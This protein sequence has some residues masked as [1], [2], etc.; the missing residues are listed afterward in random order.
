MGTL[1]DLSGPV[2]QE[3]VLIVRFWN[4]SEGAVHSSYSLAP[5]NLGPYP[6]CSLF[7][8]CLQ[9]IA[10]GP[11]AQ[12]VLPRQEILARKNFAKGECPLCS[13]EQN[14]YRHHRS[15]HKIGKKK[16]TMKERT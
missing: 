7:G 1:A 12:S 15:G 2:E 9:S 16:K 10:T 11:F 4:S 6:L 14:S 5:T 13:H 8:F 3:Q